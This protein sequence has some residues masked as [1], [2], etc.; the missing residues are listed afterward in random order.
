MIRSRILF[1]VLTAGLVVLPALPRPARALSIA[2]APAGSGERVRGRV[3]STVS[4]YGADGV[5]RTEVVLVDEGG[6]EAARFTVPGGRDGGD[7][8]VVDGV[9]AFLPGETVEVALVPTALGSTVAAAG[10]AVVR[11]A[12]A[13]DGRSGALFAEAGID[14]ALVPRIDS[15]D[16]ELSGA[17]PDQKTIVTLRGSR[18]GAVQGESRI[19]FQ[20]LFERT[21]APVVFWSDTEI[22]CHVPVPGLLGTPQVLSGTVKVWTPAGGW[23]DGD[24]FAGGPR[25]RILYQWA[26]DAWRSGNLPVG[27]YVNPDGFPWG[28]RPAR[29]WPPPSSAGTCRART[30]GSSIAASPRP[31]PGRTAKAARARATTGTRSAG[32]PP[33]RTTRP[34][35]P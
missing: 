16:P 33:G 17:A 6:G 12:P 21:D 34:G 28:P 31:R 1:F 13:V 2:G 18:F 7:L 32:A 3:A 35:W 19:T 15:V 9:P 23:S 20:G 8:W 14:T 11:L 26:G 29:S 27:V 25:F 5:L 4:A 10:D 30:R 22:R 24:P